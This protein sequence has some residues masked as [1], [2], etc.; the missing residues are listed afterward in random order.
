MLYQTEQAKIQSSFNSEL[1]FYQ[2]MFNSMVQNYNQSIKAYTSAI[3]INPMF[4][5]AFLNRATTRYLMIEYMNSLDDFSPI[6]SI[7]GDNAKRTEIKHDAE[8]D[9]TEVIDD[10]DRAIE[11]NPQ[12][13]IAYYNRGNVKCMSKD[14]TGAIADYTY[15]LQIGPE[16]PQAYYNRGLTLIYLKEK[17]KG[18]ID[19]SKAGELGIDDAYA[20]LKKYCKK[21]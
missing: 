1:Y 9:Y 13:G 17:E 19:I 15:S 21:E 5:L 7:S 20:V 6:I 18:C 4:E 3:S 8:N 14:F 16:L 2:A 10:L 11:L 12:L